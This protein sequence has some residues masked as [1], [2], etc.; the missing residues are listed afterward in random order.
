M[1]TIDLV[2]DDEVDILYQQSLTACVGNIRQ[3]FLQVKKQQASC[4]QARKR[5]TDTMFSKMKSP[6]RM[7][8]DDTS[9]TCDNPV[10]IVEDDENPQQTILKALKSTASAADVTSPPTSNTESSLDLAV[11][12]YMTDAEVRNFIRKLS[13]DEDKIAQAKL[14]ERLAIPSY[15]GHHPSFRC[16]PGST[17]EYEDGTFLTIKT[18]LRDGRGEV[19]LRGYKLVRE[20]SLGLMMPKRRNEVVLVR[21]VPVSNAHNCF[22]DHDEISIK[23]IR[24]NRKVLFTNQSFPEVSLRDDEAATSNPAFDVN[25]GPLFCRWSYTRVVNDR[26]KSVENIVERIDEQHADKSSRPNN[27]ITS[28]PEQYVRDEWRRFTTNL[29]GSHHVRESTFNLDGTAR[30]ADTQAYTFGDAFCGA[31][32]VSRGALDAGLR[33]MWAFDFN[34]EAMASYRTNFAHHGADC[35][36]ESVDQFIAHI[37]R[38]VELTDVLVDVL[39][40]SPPCQPFSPAHTIPSPERDEMNQAA[41]PAV[42]Q[43]VEKLKPR[44][45]TIEETEGLFTRHSEWFFLLVN[46]FTCFGYSVRWKVVQCHSYGVPQ[47]RKRLLIIAAG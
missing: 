1:T 13:R 9:G 12:D 21:Q 46:T 39:H 2:S 27:K 38:L 20:N 30:M 44:V 15:T 36:H 3:H 11:G 35:R 26:R 18:V 23:G 19:F 31:G 33:L 29:G 40:I 42:W 41:L 47:S 45:V 10:N 34:G 24:R 4:K 8:R 32:G 14:D 16:V 22:A 25:H 7:K 5:D 37:S 17:V 6:K 43:L 28:V